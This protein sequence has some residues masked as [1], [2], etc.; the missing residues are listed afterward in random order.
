[1][2]ESKVVH[3]NLYR[4]DRSVFKSSKNDRSEVQII[5][6][7]NNDNCQ[8]FQRGECACRKGLFGGSCQY[9]RSS[10]QQGFTRRARKYN[11]WCSEK[12]KIGSKSNLRN[13]FQNLSQ[14]P[15]Y[16]PV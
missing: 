12:K 6:C 5:T 9:G 14:K 7:T 4:P 16:W 8:L 1:M 13:P 3:F 15:V 11:A 2:S 10:K